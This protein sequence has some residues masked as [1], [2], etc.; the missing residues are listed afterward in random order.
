MKLILPLIPI[1]KHKPT[2]VGRIALEQQ[3][4]RKKF[5]AAGIRTAYLRIPNQSD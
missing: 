3:A 5:D 2:N 1:C 4:G